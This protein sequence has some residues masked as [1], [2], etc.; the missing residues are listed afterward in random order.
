MAEVKAAAM[1]DTRG[2]TCPE[3]QVMIKDKLASIKP[4][5]V[6]EVWGDTINR[7]S[8]ECFARMRGHEIINPTEEGAVYKVFM[9]KSEKERADIPLSSCTLNK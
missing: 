5:E 2:K 6:L 8:I 9:R 7:R 4:G 3:P 1:V